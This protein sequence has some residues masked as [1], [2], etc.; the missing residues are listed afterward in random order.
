MKNRADSI[1]QV[2][3]ET[4]ASAKSP[5]VPGTPS[6]LRAP[7]VK[8]TTKG[9]VGGVIG[10]VWKLEITPET[11]ITSLK[12]TASGRACQVS[13]ISTPMSRPIVIAASDHKLVEFVQLGIK[14]I[15]LVEW[16]NI[17]FLFLQEQGKIDCGFARSCKA[18][19]GY[20]AIPGN[21]L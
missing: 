13:I 14:L 18:L 12:D 7:P 4:A 6:P 21:L 11:E 16:F 10:K 5:K 15:I 1:S 9:V 20:T 19:Q 3:V 2:S 8:E 17:E